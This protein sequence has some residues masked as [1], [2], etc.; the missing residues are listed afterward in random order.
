MKNLSFYKV[1]L[2]LFTIST[3]LASP[4]SSANNKPS[5]NNLCVFAPLRAIQ[6]SQITGTITVDGMP[7]TGVSIKVLGKQET[8]V[9]REDGKFTINADPTDTLIFAFVG[10]KTVTEP[11]KGRTS[12]NIQLQ[13]DQTTLQEVTVNAGYYS[14]KE[15]ERTGSIAK[16]KASDIEHQPVSSPLAAMQGRMS[17]VNI[18]QTAGTPGSG[19][20][21][22]IRGINSLRGEG[23]DPL[24]I[25][26]GVP[27]ASQSLGN[28]DVSANL[29]GGLSSPLSNINPADI[30]S[31][32]VLKDADA[33][34]IYGSRGAN[35]VVLIT[36]KKGKA[37]KTKFEVQT[38][39]TIG[40]IT[41]KINL[42]NTQEYLAMRTEA[43]ANDG[44]TAY[45]EDAYD[46]NGTWD[47]TRYTNWQK[48]L[49]GGTANIYNAQVSVSGGSA[50]TQFLVSGTYR[51]ETTVFPGEAHFN[52]GAVAAN[53]NHRSE[54]DKF[55][56]MFSANYTGDKNTLPGTDLTRQAYVLAPN[57][58]ALYDGAG[59]L[60]WENGTFENPLSYLNGKYINTANTLL[61]NALLSYKLP[62]GFEIKTSLGF[63]D[64]QLSEERSLP[65][66]MYN[67][68]YNLGSE[69][70]EMVL[71]D[72]KRRSWIIEP[73]INWQKKWKNIDVNML[74]GT[75]FQTQKQ[76]ALALDAYGFA[77]NALMNSVA[78]A[79]TITILNDS[80][81]EYKYNA[82]FGRLNMVL[83]DRYIL[84]LTGR[85]DGS[86]RFGPD[87]RFANFGA[88]GAA[89]IFSNEPLLKNTNTILSFGKLRASYG[90]T[91][92]DQIGDYQYLD[93]YQVTPNLY[94]GVTGI[95][96]TRLFNP[97]FGWE[98]N[99]KFEAALELGFLKDRI[100][101]T[102]AYFQNR[103]SNQLVGVPLPGTTG[104]PSLQANLDAT[105]QNTGL[106]LDCRTVN[107]KSKDFSWI[108]SLNLTVPRNKLLEFPDL[109]A[110]T[111]KN[112]F[113][114][115][116]SIFIQKLYHYTGLDAET[117]LYTVED[118]NGDGEITA[119]G[120]MN[121]F[122]DF[123]PKYYGGVANQLTYKNLTL[124]VLFQFVKQKGA[125]MASLFPVAGSFSNQP[126]QVLNHYP[127]NG[128]GATTQPYTTGENPDALE[129]YN[130][131]TLSDAMVQDASF[132]RLKSLS[133]TYA[134][135][136]SWSKSVSS[137]IYVQGQNLLTFTKYKGADPENKSGYYL[138]PLKQFT[139]GVQLSF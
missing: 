3:I 24:Y 29:F 14:V 15:K 81:S 1:W 50:A 9:S 139:L 106:E 94:D 66:T 32:E 87:N 44:I 6:Q 2:L 40:K 111:Y 92:N 109:D 101:L 83:K 113:V 115:G 103:S 90:I 48:E 82:F 45:P 137:K 130:N 132:V 104:F 41:N 84:N 60:N 18:T 112:R 31:I 21:I 72:G 74:V 77:S 64:S 107:F 122:I 38:Y 102:T 61:A 89:W 7:M 93:T 11:L 10:F 105:V 17:G 69:V 23:N 20:N 128:I 57:A 12:L 71:N 86:S 121:S 34:A 126:I 131:Y 4:P 88:M 39:T 108:T 136:S 54:D 110:S 25:I 95:Q 43:F 78:A 116:E 42:L 135:P 91:G 46:I 30:E 99:K 114:I 138:P 58:P 62:A 27:Y 75:T 67:P 51:K 53:I 134:M 19:F 120:D 117:G 16:I 59:N 49:I 35:G 133:L 22:Q 8:A 96:P 73:Q 85:R 124:D 76:K 68:T 97:N 100:F 47:Q 70:S 36:T 37:G 98:T 13:E 80:Q 55:S 5:T 26:N 125:D 56:M 65:N 52:R 33:T 127:Q 79:T 28:S 118:V 129:A 63:S 123:S 119:A